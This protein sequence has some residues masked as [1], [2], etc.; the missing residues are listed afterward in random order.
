MQRLLFWARL[1]IATALLTMGLKF[2]A[3]MMTG[4]VGLLSDALESIVNLLAA[5]LAFFLLRVAHSPADDDHAFGHEKA[6]YFSSAAEG[7]LIMVAGVAIVVGATERWLHPQPLA[8]LDI[9]M[10]IALLAAIANGAAGTMLLRAGRRHRSIALEADGHHL[11]SDVWTTAGVLAALLL[12]RFYPQLFWLDPLAASALALYLF[13]TGVLLLHRSGQGLM[14][15]ALPEAERDQLQQQ[16]QSQLHDGWAVVDMRTRQ[17]GARR[18]IEF[19]LLAPPQLTVEAAHT[20]CDQLEAALERDFAPVHISI[21]VEP[22][23]C[24]TGFTP[25]AGPSAPAAG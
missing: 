17:A 11:L 14:D 22:N 2:T 13:R 12:I 24:P 19:K 15:T 8:Q 21:H 7:V 5:T 18:F 23:H 9:G 10:V 20:V 16:I 3:W 1:S 25:D 4:S 6:E